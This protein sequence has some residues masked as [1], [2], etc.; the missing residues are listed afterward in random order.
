MRLNGLWR[1][2]SWRNS[3]QQVDHVRIYSD[4]LWLQSE[5]LQQI[6]LTDETFISVSAASLSV[7]PTFFKGQVPL[8]SPLFFFFFGGSIH[9]LSVVFVKEGK[10]K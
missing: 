9:F 3:W 5:N 1:L 2:K 8:P 4:Q 7:L 6:L 10:L